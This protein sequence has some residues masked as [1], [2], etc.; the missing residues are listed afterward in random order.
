MIR[1]KWPVHLTGVISASCLKEIT[2]AN[3]KGE[4]SIQRAAC[5]CQHKEFNV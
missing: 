5:S 1:I 4:P 2:E 3:I